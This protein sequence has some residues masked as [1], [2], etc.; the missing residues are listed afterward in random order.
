MSTISGRGGV[1][2]SQVP[3]NLLAVIKVAR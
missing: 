3:A 2:G 1:F